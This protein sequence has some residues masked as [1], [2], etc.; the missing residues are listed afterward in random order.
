M[1]CASSSTQGKLC[2][3]PGSMYAM[4]QQPLSA[5]A[6]APKQRL[7]TWRRN[8][9]NFALRLGTKLKKLGAVRTNA[10]LSIGAEFCVAWK[11]NATK[12]EDLRNGE[13]RQR[14]A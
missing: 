8:T 14:R 13:R 5:T 12:T 11:R 7:W 6:L 1:P 2:L 9:S 4:S 10:W 3:G